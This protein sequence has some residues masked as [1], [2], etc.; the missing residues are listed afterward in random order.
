[1]MMSTPGRIRN[2][3]LAGHL[4]HGKTLIRHVCTA[5]KLHSSIVNEH[6]DESQRSDCTV[7]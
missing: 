2:V 3:A 6:E 1:M 4:H 5:R 7:L